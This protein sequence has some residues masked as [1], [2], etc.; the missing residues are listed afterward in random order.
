LLKSTQAKTADLE[1]LVAAE[2]FRLLHIYAIAFTLVWLVAPPN[3]Q[4]KHGDFVNF[5]FKT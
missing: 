4:A 2:S 3:S 5:V 1:S